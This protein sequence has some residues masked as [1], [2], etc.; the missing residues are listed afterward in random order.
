MQ[1]NEL[2]IGN[3]V[4]RANGKNG[5]KDIE[6]QIENINL[7]SVKK[8]EP[9]L[10]TE[11][12]LLKAGFEL[13]ED[14]QYMIDDFCFMLLNSKWYYNNTYYECGCPSK[15]IDIKYLHQLQNLHFALTQKELEIVW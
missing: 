15:P 2:R 7:Q 5:N 1:A 12:I 8:Y 3:W 10:L 11:D 13:N 14:N 6:Y 9:I 4:Y